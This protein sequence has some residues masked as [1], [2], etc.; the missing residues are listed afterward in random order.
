MSY[1]KQSGFGHIELFIVLAVTG[2]IGFAGFKVLHKD[3]EH[4]TQTQSVRPLTKEAKEY[5]HVFWRDTGKGTWMPSRKAP[6]CPKK[7]LDV[8]PAD[9][10][11]VTDFGYPGQWRG[12]YYKPHGLFAFA[13]NN[14]NRITATL[15]F[16]AS[17]V[18]IAK[19][20][21][22]SQNDPQYIMEFHH[23]CGI[24]VRF[25]HL[26]ALG[27][28]FAGF[29]SS[30]PL[31]DSTRNQ[32]VDKPYGYFKAG[33]VVATGAGLNK[34]VKGGGFD[35][36]MYDYRNANE[37]SANEKWAAIHKVEQGQTFYAI[38]WID[39]LPK[40][41]K[42]RLMAIEPFYKDDRTA[43]DYCSYAPG[44]KTLQYNN[45]LAVPENGR[46]NRAHD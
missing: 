30:L 28:E 32:P 23:E 27:P 11:Q 15:P 6:A 21:E 18:S 22:I 24:A 16:D 33:T 46:Q 4:N 41:D 37:I 34:N 17:L 10:T 36:G 1:S 5:G 39:Y 8:S 29:E 2:L 26:N 25:D 42:D 43:S 38:C 12:K 44:G 14:S 3:S 31:Q 45:G 40:A 7:I 20:K 13:R 35:F 9:T 19:Y